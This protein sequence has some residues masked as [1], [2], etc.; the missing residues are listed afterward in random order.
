MEG[1]RI[2]LAA[3]SHCFN[4][5]SMHSDHLIQKYKPFEMK[6]ANGARVNTLDLGC[7]PRVVAISQ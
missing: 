4:N 5:V 7:Q 3:P 1:C 2:T 6:A